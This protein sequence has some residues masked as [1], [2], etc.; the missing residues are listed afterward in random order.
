MSKVASVICVLCAV[1]S[2]C[3]CGVAAWQCA[4]FAD[5]DFALFNSV[6]NAQVTS[7]KKVR[8]TTPY[9]YPCLYEFEFQVDDALYAGTMRRK[10]DHGECASISQ[11]EVEYDRNS[12][13][14]FRPESLSQ[15]V[16]H[17]GGWQ[18]LVLCLLVG[19]VSAGVLALALFVPALVA[20]CRCMCSCC[21]ADDSKVTP[22]MV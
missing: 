1:L 14:T 18:P 15:R 11:V 7:V 16:M 2:V 8:G 6:T 12:P 13:A 17:P 22:Y 4:V 5:R 3:A 20:C 19:A 9:Y 21:C 10:V